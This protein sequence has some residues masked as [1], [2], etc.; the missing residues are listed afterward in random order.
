MSIIASR[1]NQ[2]LTTSSSVM[3]MAPCSWIACWP[4]KRAACPTK[5]LAEATRRARS[6][7]SVPDMADA[8]DRH[9]ARFHRSYGHVRHA[10]LQ[11]LEAADGLAELLA[12]LE[13]FERCFVQRLDD[14]DRLGAQ[15]GVG[16]VERALDHG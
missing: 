7:A 2:W 6:S 4:T 12:R 11:R 16:S 9:G 15:R 8:E 5:A 10:V 3:P 1:L 14:A 13:V